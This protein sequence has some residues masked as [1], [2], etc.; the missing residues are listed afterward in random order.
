MKSFHKLLMQK[1]EMKNCIGSIKIKGKCSQIIKA[2]FCIAIAGNSLHQ[3]H[4]PEKVSAE[5][6]SYS[7]QS[8]SP[9]T[10]VAEAVDKTGPAV[11]TI[12]TKRT[13]YSNRNGIV[14][15]GI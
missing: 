12:E 15:P 6:F 9:N 7:K 1:K 5:E 4:I 2:F 11:V 3:I 13:V 8:L 10:F 14:P